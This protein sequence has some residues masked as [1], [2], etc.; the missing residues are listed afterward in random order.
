MKAITQCL[1]YFDK[2]EN[3]DVYLNL[4]QERDLEQEI[5]LEQEIDLE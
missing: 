2:L 5:N 1:N 4:L 3:L